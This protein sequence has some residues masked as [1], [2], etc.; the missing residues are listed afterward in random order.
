M[1]VCFLY[2]AGKLIGEH[3]LNQELY[4]SCLKRR[5]ILWKSMSE[6]FVAVTFTLVYLIAYETGMNFSWNMVQS[7]TELN[8]EFDFLYQ[9]LFTRIKTLFSH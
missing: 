1:C 9:G 4:L 3:I 7:V 5:S 8:V 6:V 2:L